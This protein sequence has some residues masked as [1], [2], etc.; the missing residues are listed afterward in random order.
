MIRMATELGLLQSLD[1]SKVLQASGG[2][3]VFNQVVTRNGEGGHTTEQR[4][5]ALRPGFLKLHTVN[6]GNNVDA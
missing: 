4:L 5:Q 3:L 2:F 1:V 6:V